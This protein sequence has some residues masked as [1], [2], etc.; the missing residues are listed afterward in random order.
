MAAIPEVKI[1]EVVKGLVVVAGLAA[2]V[3]QADIARAAADLAKEY[4]KSSSREVEAEIAR[5]LRNKG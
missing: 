1:V 4:G 3:A 2:N 5:R